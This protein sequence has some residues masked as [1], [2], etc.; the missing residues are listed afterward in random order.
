MKTAAL[1]LSALALGSTGNCLAQP[2]AALARTYSDDCNQLIRTRI[3]AN[4]DEYT[5]KQRQIIYPDDDT[6]KTTASSYRCSETQGLAIDNANRRVYVIKT[7]ASS[8]VGALYSAPLSASKK[9]DFKLVGA[10]GNSWLGHANGLCCIPT[11]S[12]T[13]LFVP[14][15]ASSGNGL[16]RTIFVPNAAAV[17]G[18]DF[19]P[20]SLGLGSWICKGFRP[21]ALAWDGISKKFIARN[22]RDS[23]GNEA[24]CNCYVF[25]APTSNTEGTFTIPNV[26]AKFRVELPSKINIHAGVFSSSA[27]SFDAGKKSGRGKQDIAFHGGYLY[28]PVSDQKDKMYVNKSGDKRTNRNIILRFKT[29]SVQS[30]INVYRSAGTRL[31]RMDRALLDVSSTIE[32]GKQGYEIESIDFFGNQMYL[33]ANESPHPKKYD[34]LRMLV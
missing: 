11:G 7:D 14:D 32:K 28:L 26:D 12:G 20:S 10:F 5:V 8:K 25:A 24:F 34:T 17:D 22:G 31:Y 13:R 19:D 3:V 21:R 30:L 4:A 6:P 16:I 1:S 23:S 29:G 33:V 27:E 18:A 2:Q 15:S 9:S